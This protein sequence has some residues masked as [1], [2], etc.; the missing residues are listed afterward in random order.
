MRVVGNTLP[1]LPSPDSGPCPPL[2]SPPL[3]ALPQV[4]DGVKYEVELVRRGVGLASVS[5]NGS[6]VDVAYR[7]MGDGGFLV[8]VRQAVAVGATVA[9]APAQGPCVRWATLAVV[10]A[11][12]CS[13]PDMP[14]AAH[15][16]RFRQVDGASH[17]VHFE[18][19]RRGIWGSGSCARSSEAQRDGPCLGSAP[20]RHSWLHLRQAAAAQWQARYSLAPTPLLPSPVARRTRRRARGC[21]STAS[22]CCWPPRPT[23]RASPPARPASCCAACCPTARTWSATRPTRSSRQDGTRAV[24]Y[25]TRPALA[26]PLRMTR[27]AHWCAP[28]TVARPGRGPH[29]PPSAPLVARLPSLAR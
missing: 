21:W 11:A 23:P 7:K 8:Q 15:V 6:A 16:L 2:P 14:C 3:P 24:A 20:P 17:V 9:H 22:R 13:S 1:S 27:T 25:H 18:V 5:L 4:V 29:T 10:V 12:V 26:A 19:G 28:A